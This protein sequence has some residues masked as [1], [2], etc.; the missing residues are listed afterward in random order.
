[1]HLILK[2]AQNCTSILLL[3]LNFL[4]KSSLIQNENLGYSIV[5]NE[6]KTTLYKIEDSGVKWTK[7]ETPD[8]AIFNDLRINSQGK[9]VAVG[10]DGGVYLL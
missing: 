1:M 6:G 5:E 8:T 2:K 4:Y 9:A 3:E 10:K 7:I